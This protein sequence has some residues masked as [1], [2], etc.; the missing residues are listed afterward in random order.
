MIR[1]TPLLAALLLGACTVGP[2]YAPPATQVPSAFMGPQPAGAAVD[3]AHWWRV[4]DDR[5]LDRLVALALADNPDIQIAASRIRQA[6][7]AEIDARAAGQ[8]RVAADANVSRVDFSKNG[9]FAALARSLSG[10]GGGAGDGVAGDDTGG[11]PPP[12]TGVASP[13]SGI[14]TFAVGFDASWELDL[15]GRVRRGREAAAARAEAAVWNGRDTA[16][17]LAAEVAQAYFALRLDDQQIAAIGEEIDARART[18]AIVSH[19]ADVGLVPRVDA[20]AATDALLAARARLEPVRADRTLRA[21]AL[22]LLTAQPPGA[23]EEEL[24]NP[25][26]ALTPAPA[27]PAG[28]PSDLLRRRPDVRAAE[29][30]LAASSADVGA[31]VGDLY[32]KV[33]LTG[34]LQLLSAA[35]GNLISTDSLQTTATGAVSVPL[36]DGGR[37]RARVESRREDEE[38][39]RLNYQTTVLASLRDVEDSL[40]QIDAERRRR[41]SL[42]NAVESEDRQL[43]ALQARFRTGLVAEDPVLAQRAQ[44]LAAREQ[45]A[46]SE[47]QLRQATIALF[48]ALGGGWETADALTAERPEQGGD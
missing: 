38:Q 5:E 45:L 8:P 28:L 46:V 34:A 17:T 14:T 41:V 32:P 3:P 30:R 43:A 21:H 13:G 20:V 15:F 1:R 19:R 22:A 23:L 24:A 27:I 39:A 26:P 36:L 2:N 6:R 9:G 29:R 44:L 35:L 42:V 40:T 47:A 37:G 48:K 16:V 31:A 10:S 11:T 4:F 12:T 18:V 7:L 25:L 33:S